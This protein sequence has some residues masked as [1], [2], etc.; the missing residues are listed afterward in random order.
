MRAGRV[1]ALVAAVCLMAWPRAAGAQQAPAPDT[2]LVPA[3]PTPA[4][5]MVRSVILPGWGQAAVGSP[6]RGGVY[7]LGHT[8]NVF[9]LLKTRARLGEIRSIAG[10]R[11][12]V[13]RDS[14]AT[15]NPDLSPEELAALQAEATEDDAPLEGFRALED[16]RE[17]QR[18]DWLVWGGFW[19][20]AGAVDAYVAAQLSD[21]P[22]DVIVRPGSRGALELGLSI[23]APR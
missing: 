5:A 3:G 9:M 10:R 6:L 2:L 22:A 17:Q 12:G 1:A 16:S 19:L 18:E 20:L 23:G 15:A 4:G 11:E 14:V 13:L 7:F 8:V 21:F